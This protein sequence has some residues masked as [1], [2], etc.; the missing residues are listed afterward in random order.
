MN[1]INII[2]NKLDIIYAL[3]KK[4]A[5]QN[6][7]S[8]SIGR[9]INRNVFGKFYTNELLRELTIINS[10]FII[11]ENQVKYLVKQKEIENSIEDIK[12]SGKN[13]IKMKL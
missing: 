13:F 2:E 1:V 12:K 4:V 3:I 5:F 8:G 6:E 7:E 11:Y 10:Y 9:V